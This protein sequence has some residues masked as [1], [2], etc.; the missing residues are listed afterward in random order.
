MDGHLFQDRVELLQLQP[1]WGILFVLGGNVS[2]YA[3]F[4][5]M[6]VLRTF[7]DDLYSIAFFCHDSDALGR[8]KFFGRLPAIFLLRGIG[9]AY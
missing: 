7:Q 2:A 9:P 5:A 1:L 4:T 3:G 6:L 8:V